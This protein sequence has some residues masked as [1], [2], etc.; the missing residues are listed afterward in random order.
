[1]IFVAFLVPLGLYLVV[2]GLLNRRGFPLLVPGPLDLIGLLFGLSGFLVVG[3]PAVLSS[4]HERWRMW[5][6]VGGY[7]FGPEG[8]SALAWWQL[9]S[10]GY[11]LLVVGGCVWLF[12]QYRAFT[13]IYCVAPDAVPDALRSV[14]RES[15]LE[16]AE[17][18]GKFV[19]R[20]PGAEPA[21]VV[22]EPFEALSNVTLRWSPAEAPVRPVIE[23][24]LARE[25]V[26]AEPPEHDVGLWLCCAGLVAMALAVLILFALVM[27]PWFAS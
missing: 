21:T 6:L 19:V 20:A 15:G 23:K 10:L 2:I 7:E 13:S 25:L 14:C 22:L 1:M 11:F 5:W 16:L 4:A 3:G 18:E 9:V 26:R 12:R 27:K 17:A 8:G 24:G